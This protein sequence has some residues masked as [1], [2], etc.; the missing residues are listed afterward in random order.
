METRGI[1]DLLNLFMNTL[2]S[3]CAGWLKPDLGSISS[4]SLTKSSFHLS[5]F[6]YCRGIKAVQ[7]IETVSVVIPSD[8]QDEL[9]T[10]DWTATDKIS[11]Y[12]LSLSRALSLL[13][14][15]FP[16][17]SQPTLSGLETC[18]IRVKPLHSA[19]QIKV[20]IMHLDRFSFC[21]EGGRGSRISGRSSQQQL[22]PLAVSV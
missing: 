22:K 17:I 14:K 15:L 9:Y 6:F 16:H 20:V 5:Y 8:L 12:S 4:Q 2:A 7:N 19:L 1:L 18:I 13:F 11:L 21:G 10:W 3:V